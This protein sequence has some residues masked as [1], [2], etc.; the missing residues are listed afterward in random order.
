MT[1]N[2]GPLVVVTALLIFSAQSSAVGTWTSK[3]PLL[4]PLYAH[5]AATLNGQVHIVGGSNPAFC[6]SLLVH[7]I[8]DPVSDTWTPSAPM[9]TGRSQPAA[10]VLK[11]NGNDQLFVVGGS[12][13]CGVRTAS[14][15]AY[16][17]VTNTWTPK[18]PMP[19][20]PR[21]HMAAAVIDG[22]LYVVGGMQFDA[23]DGMTTLAEVYNPATDTWSTIAPMPNAR[24]AMAAGAI[25]GVLY[26]AGGGSNNL[27]GDF[28]AMDAYDPATDTWSSKAPISQPRVFAASAVAN[29]LL[30]MIGGMY[31]D[32][33]SSTEIYDP[34]SD[35]WTAGPSLP[36]ARSIMPAATAAG[37]IYV[38]GGGFDAFGNIVADTYMLADGIAPITTATTSIA[39][40]TS[41][42]FTADVTV[43]LQASD[44]A[45]G[46][47][48][49]SIGYSLNGSNDSV[50]ADNLEI[51][52]TTEGV[53]TLTYQATDHA[54]NIEP[55]QTLTIMLDKTAPSAADL[56]DIT[57][58]ATSAAGAVV[59]FDLAA[60]D[61]VSGIDTIVF[62]E[63]LPS[64]ST[65]PH[66]TTSQNIEIKDKAGHSTFRSFSV[67]VN[68]TLVSIAVQPATATIILGQGGQ[69]Y[70]AIGHF[71]DESDQLLSAVSWQSSNP[72]VAAIDATGFATA[73][74]VGQTTMIASAGSV[75]CQPSGC[76]TLTVADLLTLNLPSNPDIVSEATS[77]L[78]AAVPFSVSATYSHGGSEPVQCFI[79]TGFVGG[80]PQIGSQVTSGDTFPLGTTTVGCFATGMAE[81]H[82]SGFFTVT[83]Q[84]TL[85]PV[86]TTS[87]NV[88]LNAT[89]PAGA[90]ATFSASAVDLV[91]GSRP[92]TCTPAS[93]S[94]FPIGM[95]TVTCS[96][97]DA[98][99]HTGSATLTVTVL[100][101]QQIV[102]N[103]ISL[104]EAANFKTNQ[105][106]SALQNIAAGDTAGACGRLSTF[107]NQVNAQAGKS[108]SSADA[109]ALIQL[110]M[111]A[112]AAIGC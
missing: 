40:N 33:F 88:T 74:S 108:I 86:V 84:D 71:T 77:G 68:K 95:T 75:T 10:A 79:I 104:A 73:D 18:A 97:S 50:S 56:S 5:A 4:G 55:Q 76:G 23:F 110:A 25:D 38:M 82:V 57:V 44:G 9:T 3:A 59:T 62:N 16:D 87:G 96:A 47:G 26:V 30:Y 98:L 103:L 64:G 31:A 39:A 107:I 45:L 63:G 53:T 93:G 32:F 65:F 81:Q 37:A 24:Y 94:T 49:Q 102:T 21:S 85:P 17:P 60:S 89:S 29:G 14:M 78:G 19:G 43:T 90:V 83:V 11:V 28:T 46:S 48:V 101:P 99:A 35:S 13:S 2:R 54:G 6:F 58:N 12:T 92:V 20:G 70:Q 61:E 91:S 1:R 72:S 80:V 36:E 22:L 109:A 69:Q 105:L 7:D 42:W 111:E 34:V 100:G 112:S 52:I 15:E 8:Y 106:Q 41:G 51:P 27:E 66:G 67:T